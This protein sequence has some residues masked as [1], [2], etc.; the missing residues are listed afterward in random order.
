MA[1]KLLPKDVTVYMPR[2]VPV[3]FGEPQLQEACIEDDGSPT[4]T[5]VYW[6]PEANLAFTLGQGF[7]SWGNTPGPPSRQLLVTVHGADGSLSYV[8]GISNG[9]WNE[10][11]AVS[12]Q[13]DEASYS[14]KVF[15]DDES[16]KVSQAD[17]LQLVDSLVPVE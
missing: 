2:D 5:I 9:R 16:E 13:E 1:R 4:Y 10:S 17:V 8:S 3:R 11:Y 12:W 7:G 6:G 14:V 15:N